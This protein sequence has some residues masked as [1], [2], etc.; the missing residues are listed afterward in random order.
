MIPRKTI[1]AL[2]SQIE[3]SKVCDPD[4]FYP[5]AGFVLNELKALALR[6][7]DRLD[8]N[9]SRDWQNRLNGIVDQAKSQG[10]VG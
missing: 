2:G 3:Q 10:A 9:E 1:E 7:T 8:P 6:L 5:V 4:D